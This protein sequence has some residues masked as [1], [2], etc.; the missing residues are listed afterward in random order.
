MPAA[1]VLYPPPLTRLNPWFPGQY[2]V[3]G[4]DAETG[5]RMDTNGTIR[6]VDPN[7][8]GVSDLRDGTNPIEP[9]QTVAAA[10]THCTAHS[11]DVIVVA[12]NSAWRHANPAVGRATSI[13]EEVTVS[14][15]GIR[16]VGLA[17]SSSLG[18]PWEPVNASGVMITVNAIDV[19]IEGFCFT[20]YT[21]GV[22]NAIGIAAFW[23]A[24]PYGDSLTVRNCHFG[25]NLDYGI[26]LDYSYYTDIHDNY[27]D[28]IQV[29]AIHNLSVQG[30]PD[31]IRIHDN[32]F[33]SCAIA[34]H[35]PTTGAGAIYRNLI[36]GAAGGTNNFIN[37]TGGASNIVADNYFAC[38]VAQYDVTCSDATS[39][40]WL[41]NHCV[42][43]T[44]AAPPV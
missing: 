10:L 32:Q 15:P 38:T 2:G 40:A 41:H 29:A 17:P 42:N 13:T 5:L 19:L 8:V 31:Y 1:N 27:F 22:G 9:L 11:N 16:I 7:A 37:L 12:P 14:V 35:L 39:G 30:D 34:M 36:Y 21:V 6:Y 25:E 3:P 24:P 26:T 23:N 44:P 18:V 43:G 20:D 33:L 28:N 4:T